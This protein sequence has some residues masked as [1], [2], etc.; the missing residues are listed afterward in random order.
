M[1]WVVTGT[2][3]PRPVYPGKGPVTG[4]E[5]LVAHIRLHP[6]TVQPVAGRY[7]GLRFST[8]HNFYLFRQQVA[9]RL[10]LFAL[11]PTFKKELD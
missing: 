6:R 7:N 8:F 2:L 10:G 3:H 4:T 11:S 5:N 1:G 9:L